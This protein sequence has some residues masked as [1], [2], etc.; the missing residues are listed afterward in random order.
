MSKFTSNNTKKMEAPGSQPGPPSRALIQIE[1]FKTNIASHSDYSHF[2]R[3]YHYFALRRP[4][5]DA[6]Q[7]PPLAPREPPW[8]PQELRTPRTLFIRQI[9]YANYHIIRASI[10]IKSAT[11]LEATGMSMFGSL[12]SWHVRVWNLRFM[13]A[14]GEPHTQL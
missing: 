2:F 6:F 1:F 3:K 9:A 8:P 7:R 13:Q 11:A 10:T 12:L 5:T 4:K 14:L